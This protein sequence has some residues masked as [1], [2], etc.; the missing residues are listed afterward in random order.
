MKAK[1]RVE[2]MLQQQRCPKYLSHHVK[3]ITRALPL[4]ALTL[5]TEHGFR[6][7]LPVRVN[8]CFGIQLEGF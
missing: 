5:N 6:E 7:G 4:L 1:T 8:C 2:V 3:A